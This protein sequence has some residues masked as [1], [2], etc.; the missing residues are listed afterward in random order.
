MVKVALVSAAA[1]AMAA[2]L[3]PTVTIAPGVEMTTVNLGTCCGSDPK[4]GLR[5]WLKA[6]GT[7]IDTAFDYGIQADIGKILKEEGIPRESLFITSKI[8]AGFGNE[9]DCAADPEVSLR[10]ARENLREIGLEYFDLL[11]LH[12]PCGKRQTDL[13]PAERVAANAALWKGLVQARD[14]KLTR[15][16]GVSNYV[17]EDLEQL[18]SPLPAV[19]QCNMGVQQHD[20]TTIAYCQEKGIVYEAFRAMHGC[21]FGDERISSISSSHNVTDAQVCLRYI[22]DK[23]VAIAVGTGSDPEK[24][25]REAAENLDIY[26]FHLT[27]DEF[28]TVDGIQNAAEL[29]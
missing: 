2:P 28:A 15:S 17:V 19:N 29:V 10:Y 20:D 25:P 23:G 22:L 3:G 16:I 13:T 6:G 24:S 1:T 14:L 26:G 21:P 11:L 27:D 8:P 12:A 7:G 9:T 5:P 4:V 18:P